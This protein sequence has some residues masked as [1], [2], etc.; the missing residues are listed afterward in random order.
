MLYLVK[1]N[2][3]GVKCEKN[4]HAD[5]KHGFVYGFALQ[6][7]DIKEEKYRGKYGKYEYSYRKVS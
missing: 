6:I 1:I 7:E 4:Y 5:A 2:I 3:S